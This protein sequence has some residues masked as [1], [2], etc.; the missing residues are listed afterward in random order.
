MFSKLHPLRAG[1]QVA[2]G[3]L[4]LRLRFRPCLA[5]GSEPVRAAIVTRKS[6]SRPANGKADRPPA[7]AQRRRNSPKDEPADAGSKSKDSPSPRFSYSRQI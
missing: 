6:R 5:C 1:V 3:Q 2:F 4:R 7:G